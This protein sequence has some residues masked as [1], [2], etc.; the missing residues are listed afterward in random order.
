MYVITLTCAVVSEKSFPYLDMGHKH[1][2]TGVTNI[3]QAIQ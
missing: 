2:Q 1:P 3:N